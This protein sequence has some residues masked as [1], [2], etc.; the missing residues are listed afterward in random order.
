[1]N[2]IFDRNAIFFSIRYVLD[3]CDVE[4]GN[5]DISC[6]RTFNE[7][8]VRVELRLKVHLILYVP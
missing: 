4:L 5:I 1:M 3:T 6:A 8:L 2:S 7:S